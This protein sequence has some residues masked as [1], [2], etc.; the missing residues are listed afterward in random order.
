MISLMSKCDR[1]IYEVHLDTFWRDSRTRISDFYGFDTRITEVVDEATLVM[2]PKL[3]GTN[4]ADE[5]EREVEV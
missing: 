5:S 3:L 2:V 1:M 4:D